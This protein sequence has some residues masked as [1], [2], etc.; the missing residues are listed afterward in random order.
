M[1]YKTKVQQIKRK[2]SRQ[3]YITLP[4]ALAQAMEFKKGETVE[5]Q[6]DAKGTLK[7]RR[8]ARRS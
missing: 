8:I 3:W 6:I 4:S 5:W 7:L 1:G 2:R